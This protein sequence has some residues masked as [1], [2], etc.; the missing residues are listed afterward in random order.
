MGI[1]N[2]NHVGRL[3]EYPAMAAAR[4]NGRHHHGQRPRRG[5]AIVAPFGGA[6]GRMGDESH[7]GWH[8]HRT[9]RADRAR[10]RHQRGSGGQGAG[11][12]QPGFAGPPWAGCVNNQ[13]VPTT[14]PND[15]YTTPR[16]A[17]LP[18]GGL[19]EGHKGYGLALI[20]EILSGALTRAGC[21]HPNPDAQR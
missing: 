9:G 10:H 15:L 21:A 8:S 16:G 19:S 13:G 11:Q 18:L 1:H 7:L 14:D 2:C 5:G 17:I 4:G 3:G 6:E 12:A 20:I